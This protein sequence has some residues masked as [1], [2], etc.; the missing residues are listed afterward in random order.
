MGKIFGTKKKE[1]KPV[2][3]QV[4]QKAAVAPCEMDTY[5]QE[6]TIGWVIAGKSPSRSSNA[7][8]RPAADQQA[9]QNL[10]LNVEKIPPMPEVWHKLQN[11]LQQVDISVT[12]LGACVAQDPILTAKVLQ[13]SNSAAYS[14]NGDHKLEN[15]SIALARLGLDKSIS[16]IMSSAIPEIKVSSDKVYDLQHIWFHSQAISHISRAISEGCGNVDRH[17]ISMLGM[18]HDIGKI[19][20]TH[21]EPRSKLN[22]LRALIYD[23]AST[24]D[25]EHTVLGYTHLDAGVALARHWD[26]PDD[27]QKKIAFHEHLRQSSVND[28]PDSL[29]IP[30]TTIHSAHIILQHIM[31]LKPDAPQEPSSWQYDQ[32]SWEANDVLQILQQAMHLP[33]NSKGIYSCLVNDILR[34]K[35]SFPD[36]FTA[37]EAG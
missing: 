18:F 5:F 30:I 13:V 11:I 23:G 1:T 26:F 17:E 37:S 4:K 12:D 22:Q 15:I 28:L 24:L 35:Q 10:L 2:R 31:Q 7:S 21:F 34:L 16:I 33:L 19:I 36:I 29:Q 8:K 14:N 27:F 9:L 32:Q 3:K 6:Q 20:I 25:A